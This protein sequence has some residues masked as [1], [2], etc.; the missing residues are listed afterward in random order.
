MSVR[1]PAL[2]ATAEERVSVASSWRLVWWR[3]RKHRLALVSAVVLIALY[4]VVLC[5]DFFSTQ[6]P[7]ATDARLA[8]IPDPAPPSLR[9]RASEPVGPRRDGRAQSDDPPHGV[10]RRREPADPGSILRHGLSVPLARARPDAASPARRGRAGRA[11]AAPSPGH[12]PARA[13]SVVAAGARHADV[14]D[15]RPHRRHVLGRPRRA[16]G[17]HLRLRRRAA[18]ARHPAADRAT[19]IACRRSRSGWPSPR[20]CR[21][22]GRPSRC[23]SRSP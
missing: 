4:V 6:D 9:R 5:P 7:E 2:P 20:R 8:F 17:R 1:A 14:D 10:A 22:T 13:R 11:R 16:A 15:D 12:R 18:D 3:F 23:S 21:A 19:A